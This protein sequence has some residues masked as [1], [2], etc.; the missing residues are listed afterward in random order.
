MIT[1]GRFD[2]WIPES[3]EEEDW[4]ADFIRR[5][6]ETGRV[7]ARNTLSRAL[8]DEMNRQLDDYLAIAKQRRTEASN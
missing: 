8:V 5:L 2:G 7:T 1:E 4:A 6:R 3:H